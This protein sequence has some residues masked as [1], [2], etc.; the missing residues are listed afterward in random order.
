M[1]VFSKAEFT[2]AFDRQIGK[3]LEEL[4]EQYKFRFGRMTLIT[5]LVFLALFLGVR[6]FFPP[7]LLVFLLAFYLVYWYFSGRHRRVRRDL[8]EESRRAILKGVAQLAVDHS[9]EAAV[10]SHRFM[11][12]GDFK[13]SALFKFEPESYQGGDL[14]DLGSP[15]KVEICH[16]TASRP[17]DPFEE[18]EEFEF[19]GYLFKIKPSAGRFPE[20]NT[21]LEGLPDGRRFH[22]DGDFA[23]MA[24][25]DKS[26]LLNDKVITFGPDYDSLYNLYLMMRQARLMA[27]QG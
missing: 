12:E 5:V 1:T 2:T 23:W 13:R 10:L 18:Q 26:R 17:E 14:I 22:W 20:D 25:P 11:P 3:D 9:G 27:A 19:E 4:K 24:Y 8:G 16:I 21:G 6:A 7:L 15:G